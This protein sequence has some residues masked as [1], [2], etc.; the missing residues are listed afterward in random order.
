MLGNEKP[1][2]PTRGLTCPRSPN[3]P[4]EEHRAAI[5]SA[6]PIGA[7]RSRDSS[8]L[9]VPLEHGGQSQGPAQRAAVLFPG[10]WSGLRGGPP[11]P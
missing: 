10:L 1:E 2:A 3:Q 6:S 9:S 11:S 8:P 4:G 7:Q 5:L